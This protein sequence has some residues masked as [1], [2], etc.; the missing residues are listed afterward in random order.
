MLGGAARID[1]LGQSQKCLLEQILGGPFVPRR[2]TQ[3]AVEL[4]VVGLE[5][6]RDGAIP[7]QSGRRIEPLDI[8]EVGP[9]WI[10]HR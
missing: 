3:E 4:G 5:R 8:S 1:F 2:T 6:G 7:M 9:D 10:R